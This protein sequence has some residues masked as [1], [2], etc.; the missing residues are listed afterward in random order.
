V[1]VI[2]GGSGR[3]GQELVRLFKKDGKTVVNVGRSKNESADYNFLHDLT[4]GEEIIAAAKEVDELTEPLEA[5]I[6][7]AGFY[8]AQ[9]L[10]EITEEE[11]K[12]NM[13]THV[14]LPML[15]VSSLIDRIKKDGTDIVN[16]ASIAAVRP[17]A[18]APA[19]GASKSAL[20]GFSADLQV[21]LKD[22]PS[23]VISFLPASFAPG[24][25]S[26]METQDVAKL[27]RQLL[28]LPKDMEVSEII[29]NKKGA[30]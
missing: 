13:A 7:T 1:I 25:T 12:R 14:K 30:A 22:Y 6:N 11:I 29:I 27:I 15:L 24:D 18:G 5:I 20:R 8:K 2:V 19:Y 28:N 21:A 4:K 23:R 10:G 26:Q 17:S 3:L 9:S 16:I